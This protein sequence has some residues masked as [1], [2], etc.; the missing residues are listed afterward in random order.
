M[1]SEIWC[2]FS[3]LSYLEINES[4]CTSKQFQ[5]CMWT[6][7]HLFGPVKE[8][9]HHNLLHMQWVR[10]DNKSCRH[11]WITWDTFPIVTN[12]VRIRFFKEWEKICYIDFGPEGLRAPPVVADESKAG[13]CFHS[14]C[15]FFFLL[16]FTHF[17]N[18][19]EDEI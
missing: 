19:Q 5:S 12:Y 14:I 3:N 4:S 6:C 18:T 10:K 16:L 1:L 11:P 9:S 17:G 7:L 2:I 13:H 15:L 8:F